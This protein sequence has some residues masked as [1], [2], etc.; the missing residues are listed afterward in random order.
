MLRLLPETELILRSTTGRKDPYHG[1]SDSVN[2][3]STV[4]VFFLTTEVVNHIDGENF[5]FGNE[6]EMTDSGKFDRLEIYAR[7]R[8]EGAEEKHIEK[9]LNHPEVG[10]LEYQKYHR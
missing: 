9:E 4:C 1:W 8:S 3:A 6:I 10:N 5:G 7:L 2:P